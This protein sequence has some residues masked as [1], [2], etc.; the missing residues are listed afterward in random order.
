MDL[1]I[2]LFIKFILLGLFLASTIKIVELLQKW[3][4]FN[5]F[6][7]NVCEFCMFFMAGFVF[8]GLSLYNNLP[9]SS[10]W[11]IFACVIGMAIFYCALY[12]LNNVIKFKKSP[13][14]K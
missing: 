7:K 4:K 5:L 6:F 14:K 8:M 12:I 1:S 11:Y 2:L 3:L 13:T 10:M 9:L